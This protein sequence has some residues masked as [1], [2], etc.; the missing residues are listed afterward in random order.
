VPLEHLWAGW[1]LA[2]VTGTGTDREPPPGEGSLF[3]RILLLD[4]ETGRIV[5]RRATCAALLNAYPYSNGHL[6]VV[7]NR[8][9]EDLQ[10]LS[11]EEHAELWDMVR[12]GVQALRTA[13]S[14]DGVNIGANLGGAAGAGV[15]GHL[16]VHCVA[17]WRGDT[18]FM[19]A[20]AETRVLPQS[21]E[22]S[23]VALRAAWPGPLWPS[24]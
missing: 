16:H 18:N 11:D 10:E 12:D 21:L 2:Y 9:V 22:D 24:R 23:W 5:A 15:P 13:F 20:V 7:P 3:E 14:C 6:L 1:R 17:R 19:T 4:D 8:A